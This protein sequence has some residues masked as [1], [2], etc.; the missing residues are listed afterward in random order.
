MIAATGAF[1]TT[2]GGVMYFHA[3]QGGFFLMNLG[4][5]L[6]ILMMII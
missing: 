2:T 3:Y 6:I 5:F 1:A 4:L